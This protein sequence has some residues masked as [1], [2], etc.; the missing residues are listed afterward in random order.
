M[1]RNVTIELTT[2]TAANLTKFDLFLFI[3]DLLVAK[4]EEKLVYCVSPPQ[5]RVL[6]IPLLDSI[7]QEAKAQYRKLGILKCE[8]EA[9]KTPK[10]T[11]IAGQYDRTARKRGVMPEAGRTLSAPMIR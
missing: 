7:S 3:V 1:R 8:L 6:W 4:C 11:A 10:E 5:E 9:G 2:A